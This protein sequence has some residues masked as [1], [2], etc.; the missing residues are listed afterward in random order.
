MLCSVC[1]MIIIVVFSPP[2]L[3]SS[4]R[5]ACSRKCL[6]K[7]ILWS[8]SFNDSNQSQPSQPVKHWRC[9]RKR[10]LSQNWSSS[11]ISRYLRSL[12]SL[13]SPHITPS[14]QSRT[15]SSLFYNRNVSYFVIRHTAQQGDFNNILQAW[16]K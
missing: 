11:T 6:L 5:G 15:I 10:S 4:L 2:S 13:L 12:A 9:I 1:S 7:S 14:S 3:S 8:L 16:F